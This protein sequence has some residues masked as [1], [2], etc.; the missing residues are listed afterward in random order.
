MTGSRM[1]CAM[2]I[3]LVTLLALAGCKDEETVILPPPPAPEAAPMP[4]AAPEPTPAAPPV[5]EATAYTVKRGDTLQRIARE[6][7]GSADNWEAILEANSD[8][9]TDPDE[10]FVGQV[11]KVP[12]QPDP[13]SN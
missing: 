1:H 9:I 2:A 4:S 12:A 6:V 7:Y 5:S 8:Q 10:I 11:L 3:A 13:A